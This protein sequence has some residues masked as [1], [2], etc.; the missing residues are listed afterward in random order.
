[1]SAPEERRDGEHERELVAQAQMAEQAHR[2]RAH[3]IGL[4]PLRTLI[5]RRYTGWK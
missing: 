3:A 2:L 1:M 4:A 5:H